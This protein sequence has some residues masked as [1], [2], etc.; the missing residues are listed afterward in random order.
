MGRSTAAPP[1]YLLFLAQHD[2]IASIKRLKV[3][4]VHKNPL[5]CERTNRLL[6]FKSFSTKVTMT[7]CVKSRTDGR[8]RL[9]LRDTCVNDVDRE[10]CGI[11]R[12]VYSYTLWPPT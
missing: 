2:T 7:K 3:S 1:I 8:K 11:A 6:K 9:R 12:Y 5:N 4:S 10:R